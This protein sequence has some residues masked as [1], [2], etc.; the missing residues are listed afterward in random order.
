MKIYFDFDR[1]LFDT[2]AFLEELYQ[3]LKKHNIPIDLF[4]KIRLED[5]DNGFNCF[6]I[7]EKLKDNYSFNSSLYV[8]LEH[9]LEC[10]SRYLFNDSEE[11]L[12]YLKEHHYQLI[13]LTKGDDDFQ[14]AKID[15]TNIDDYFDDIIVTNN[16]KG[17]LDI[18]YH[19]IFIDDNYEELESIMKNNPIKVI[20]IDRYSKDKNNDKRFLTIHSLKELYKIIND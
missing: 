3:I 7:L 17:E 11:L 14:K 20:H 15:N 2:K 18:Y 16:H 13:L 12:K 6:R 5:K 10:D 1:T 8:D 9:L 19:A 4:D